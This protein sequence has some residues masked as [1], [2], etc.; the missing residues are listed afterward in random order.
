MEEEIE[1][2]VKAFNQPTYRGMK[3][4]GVR[5]ATWS[6]QRGWSGRRC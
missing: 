5:M 6:S 4:I 2:F 3:I 1:G